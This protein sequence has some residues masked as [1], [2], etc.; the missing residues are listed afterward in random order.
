VFPSYILHWAASAVDNGVS[1]FSTDFLQKK[2]RN[3][4][5]DY[6]REQLEMFYSAPPQG[7]LSIGF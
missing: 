7:E 3:F 4:G 5:E 2:C 1:I 6:M